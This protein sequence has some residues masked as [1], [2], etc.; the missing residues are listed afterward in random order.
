MMVV[1]PYYSQWWLNWIDGKCRHQRR[2]YI[3]DMPQDANRTACQEDGTGLAS[4]SPPRYSR[5]DTRSLS[6]STK[7]KITSHNNPYDN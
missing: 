5:K 1:V 2:R 6:V 7:A 3:D 4:Y